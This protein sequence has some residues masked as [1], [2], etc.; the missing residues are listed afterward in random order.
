IGLMGRNMPDTRREWW[1]RLGATLLICFSGWTLLAYFAL[2]GPRDVLWLLNHDAAWFTSIFVWVGTTLVGFLWGASV[3]TPPVTMDRDGRTTK[4]HEWMTKAK[5]FGAISR[6]AP[7]VFIAGLAMLL[8]YLLY[9]FANGREQVP[10]DGY[11]FSNLTVDWWLPLAM[12][13]LAMLL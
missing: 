9:I 13:G 12:A 10:L 5:T 8:S 6:L 2:Y 1:S 11:W 3:Q 4:R 7:F